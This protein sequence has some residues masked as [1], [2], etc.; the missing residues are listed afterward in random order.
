MGTDQICGCGLSLQPCWSDYETV[1]S[2]VFAVCENITANATCQGMA[3][4]SDDAIT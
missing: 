2:S 3:T 4:E 1:V